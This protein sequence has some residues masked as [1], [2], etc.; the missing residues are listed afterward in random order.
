MNWSSGS[1][2][3][4]SHS[5]SSTCLST[6]RTGST[7]PGSSGQSPGMARRSA[8]RGPGTWRPRS[9]T[10]SRL[11]AR[12]RA[13]AP[14]SQLEEDEALQALKDLALQA[15]RLA[16]N[17]SEAFNGFVQ[18]RFFGGERLIAEN[19]RDRQ[20]KL[21]KYNHLAANCLIFQRTGPDTHP[22]PASR[23]RGGVRRSDPLTAQPV[24]H[25]A[26]QPVRQVHAGSR[27]RQ[28]GPGLH[29]RLATGHGTRSRNRVGV[30]GPRC[31]WPILS[32]IVA[33]PNMR[34]CDR[35]GR[36]D[37]SVDLL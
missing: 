15:Y 21:I 16:T 24:S 31:Q 28:F 10:A 25:G 18:W 26:R 6:Q 32:R 2:S 27:P 34:S 13:H 12:Y 9:A 11:P 29:A 23:G 14:D 33:I 35:N 30:R 1:R 8:P 19:D 5:T 20:R 4:S 3:G 36:P 17:K 22:A 37:N 7:G